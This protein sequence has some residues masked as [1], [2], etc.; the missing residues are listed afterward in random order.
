MEN[1]MKKKIEIT[2]KEAYA[3]KKTIEVMKIIAGGQLLK[4]MNRIYK[5]IDETF[6]L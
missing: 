2:E 3:L 5:K 4:A 1:E 6:N